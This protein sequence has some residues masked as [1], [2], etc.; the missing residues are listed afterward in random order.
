[1]IDAAAASKYADRIQLIFAGNGPREAKLRKRG[2]KLANPPIFGF[3]T[4]DELAGVINYCDLY[5]HPSDVEIEAISCL[6]ALSCGLVPV[7]SDSSRSATKQFALTEN[8][9]FSAGDPLSLA[10]K[11]DYWLEHPQEKEELSAK[12]IEFGKSFSS[13]T[14]VD[15]MISTFYEVIADYAKE[16]VAREAL[17]EQ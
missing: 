7:I 1:L 12:Y 14:C 16:Q 2:Q 15:Q 8:N 10:L 6:E 13:S 5:V 9:L 11:I 17:S 4:E 3:F